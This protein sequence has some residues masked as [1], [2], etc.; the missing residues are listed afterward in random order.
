VIKPK[1][2]SKSIFCSKFFMV[3]QRKMA[4]V[5]KIMTFAKAEDEDI[6]FWADKTWKDGS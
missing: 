1:G 4:I 3:K 6:N 2:K 5:G